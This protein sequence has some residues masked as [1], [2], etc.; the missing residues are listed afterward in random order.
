MT[1]SASQPV[2]VFGVACVFPVLALL[3]SYLCQKLV[4]SAPRKVEAYECGFVPTILPGYVSEKNFA[5]SLYL[6]TELALALLL[7]CV[8]LFTKNAQRIS[9]L[10]IKLA[11]FGLL[12]LMLLATYKIFYKAKS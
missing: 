3:A 4:P 11:T 1:S 9:T 2:I 5:V 8:C 6:I 10:A 12:S 7:A